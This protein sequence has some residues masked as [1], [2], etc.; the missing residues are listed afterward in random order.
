VGVK[1]RKWIDRKTILEYFSSMG[2]IDSKKHENYKVFVKDTE[3]NEEQFLGT[4]SLDGV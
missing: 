2:R 1:E 3:F 4:M